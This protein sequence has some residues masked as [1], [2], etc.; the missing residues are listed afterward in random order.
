M[1]SV[2]RDELAVVVELVGDPDQVVVDVAEVD[3]VR[4]G[5]SAAISRFVSWLKISRAGDVAR[6]IVEQLALQREQ[7]LE[8][9]VGRRLDDLV[10]ELVDLVAEPVEDR[11]VAVDDRVGEGVEEVVGALRRGACSTPTRSGARRRGPSRPSWTRQQ[12][13]LA[14]DEVD[15]GRPRPRRRSRARTARC[16]R[17][18]RTSRPSPA[19][20]ARRCPRR[21][22][23]GGRAP[24]RSTG[25]VVLGGVGQ[26]DPEPRRRARRRL[27]DR[28][29]SSSW[30]TG[31][32]PVDVRSAP[33]SVG[34][35]TSPRR[36]A[37]RASW[38][39][40][41]AI[42]GSPLVVAIRLRAAS[43]CRRPPRSR[44]GRSPSIR[45]RA[46]E[47][48]ARRDRDDRDDAG[49]EEQPDEDRRRLARPPS[50]RG[51][52]RRGRRGAAGRGARPGSPASSRRV[53]GENSWS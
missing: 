50:A 48:E 21:S 25:P 24:R 23:G 17:R 18:R 31:R 8:R 2:P 19:G 52:R 10:L 28:G 51:P 22:A 43:G 3:D 12:E 37:R 1:S 39:R 47:G 11:E 45:V 26:V 32:R 41:R 14:E 7:P 6:R 20:C 36:P 16:G 35:S 27:G 15:L 4:R 53:D 30:P 29:P 33:G 34:A 40:Q 13:P 46:A 38:R 5:R 42:V 9:P 44:R 49:D